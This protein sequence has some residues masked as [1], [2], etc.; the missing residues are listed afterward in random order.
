MYRSV[1]SSSSGV[2]PVHTKWAI[3]GMPLLR[4]ISMARSA[5]RSRVVPAAPQVIDTQLN[6]LADKNKERFSRDQAES[7]LEMMARV[8]STDG[9]MSNAQKAYVE[10]MRAQFTPPLKGDGPWAQ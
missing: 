9:E 5:V 8:A 4:S 7:M 2:V 6:G 1:S 3:V 10:K